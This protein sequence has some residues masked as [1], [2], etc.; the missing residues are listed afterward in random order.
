MV[1]S[2]LF[3]YIICLFINVI[4]LFGGKGLSLSI[5]KTIVMTSFV[6]STPARHG[7]DFKGINF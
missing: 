1:E 7:G 5:Q 4:L 3:K 2:L 6:I